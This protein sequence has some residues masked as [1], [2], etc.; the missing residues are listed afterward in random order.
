[1][2]EEKL[3]LVISNIRKIE[4]LPPIERSKESIILPEISYN[5]EDSSGLAERL[6]KLQSNLRVLEKQYRVNLKEGFDNKI[7]AYR[8][9][10]VV[11]RKMLKEAIFSVSKRKQHDTIQSKK[12]SSQSNTLQNSRI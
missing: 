5:Q 3:N 4:P 10:A 7:K 6:R 2:S 12:R 1:M 11:E 9:E 8:L